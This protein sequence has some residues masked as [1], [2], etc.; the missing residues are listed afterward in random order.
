MEFK[1]KF[2]NG[3]LKIMPNVIRAKNGDVEVHA[4]TPAIEAKARKEIL[5]KMARGE[6]VKD[7]MVE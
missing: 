5:E 1:A 2:V 4:L 7:Y 6:S 3:I